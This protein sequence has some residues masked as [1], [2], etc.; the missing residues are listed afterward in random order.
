M[1]TVNEVQ[2]GTTRRSRVLVVD[3]E[4]QIRRVLRLALTAQGFDVRVAEEGDG[5]IDTLRDWAAD[6]VI[7][8][9]SMPGVDGIQLCGRIR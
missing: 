7:T 4:P 5:A 2:A 6:L 1:R 8:D 3:D 9:L